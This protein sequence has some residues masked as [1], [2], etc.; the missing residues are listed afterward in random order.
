M[1]FKP[2]TKSSSDTDICWR[3]PTHAAGAPLRIT[4]LSEPG[5]KH[6]LDGKKNPNPCN[7]SMHCCYFST[8]GRNT[9]SSTTDQWREGKAWGISLQNAHT[10]TASIGVWTHNLLSVGQPPSPLE[11]LALRSVIPF[12]T[13]C[14]VTKL[15]YRIW[16]WLWYTDYD[17]FY[18]IMGGILHTMMKGY[19]AR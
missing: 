2:P 6:S 10:Q 5:D 9:C 3:C 17:L 7:I 4:C 13:Q 14:V 11:S 8:F 12:V 15:L 1:G 16:L 18:H 19:I